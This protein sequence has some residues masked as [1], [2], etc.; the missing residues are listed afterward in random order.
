MAR[1]PRF[2]ERR[3]YNRAASSHRRRPARTGEARSAMRTP[4]RRRQRKSPACR[5]RLSRAERRAGS[6]G[7]ARPAQSELQQHLLEQ[8]H[9]ARQALSERQRARG[10]RATAPR[11]PA[12]AA[13]W[14]GGDAEPGSADAGRAW[15]RRGQGGADRRRLAQVAPLH[16]TAGSPQA[17]ALGSK[18]ARGPGAQAGT[19]RPQV[20][21]VLAK[22]A[23]PHDGGG[24]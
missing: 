6:A 23:H 24:R 22:G 12:G 17:G 13:R 4:D 10:R 2:R 14:R 5:S 18:S 21:G 9:V 16:R 3:R 1:R 15:T 11:A 7:C 20:V 19:S 8:D